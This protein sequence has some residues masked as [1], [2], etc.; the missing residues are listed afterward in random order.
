MEIDHHRAE[1]TSLATA[2][3][4]VFSPFPTP[5]TDATSFVIDLFVDE[6]PPPAHRKRVHT[7][8]IVDFVYE[9]WSVQKRE[10]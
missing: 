2:Q 6:E 5:M 8:D 4:L 10:Q 3:R 7:Y 9:V 1:I